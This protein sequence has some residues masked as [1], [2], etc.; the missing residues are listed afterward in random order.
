MHGG[1][2]LSRR[3]VLGGSLAG[4]AAGI[5]AAAAAAAQ[6]TAGPEAG[7]VLP[8]APTGVKL[9]A[10]ATAGTVAWTP[11]ADMGASVVIGYRITLADASGARTVE[12]SGRDA[13]VTQPTLKGMF[14]V[15]GALT[16][17]TS[18]TVS[19]A[20]VT[21][22]GVGPAATATGRTPSA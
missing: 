19:V 15:V 9:R 7:S 2:D 20:A 10:Q 4:V 12:V 5:A 11:P 6:D 1:S 21:G 17:G 16:P 8:A 18:Y 14:R 22:T 13:L 3:T